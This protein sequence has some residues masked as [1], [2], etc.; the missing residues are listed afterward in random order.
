MIMVTRDFISTDAKTKSV[1][2]VISSLEKKG[3]GLLM[4]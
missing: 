1:A 4:P 3:N 2:G